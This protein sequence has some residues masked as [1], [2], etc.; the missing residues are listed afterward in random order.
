MEALLAFAAAL[1][2]LRLSGLLAGR[3]RERRQPQLAAWA[4]ALGAYAAA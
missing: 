1:I 3:W 4:A 2:A